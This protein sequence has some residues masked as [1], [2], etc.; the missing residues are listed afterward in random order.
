M[1]NHTYQVSD[2]NGY[3]IS[4][5]GFET[6]AV[7][8]SDTLSDLRVSTIPLQGQLLSWLPPDVIATLNSLAGAGQLFTVLTLSSVSGTVRLSFTWAGDQHQAGLV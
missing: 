2:S 7:I 8:S 3:V 4:S 5:G 6:P 1:A